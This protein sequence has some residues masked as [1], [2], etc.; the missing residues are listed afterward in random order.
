MFASN[1][2]RSRGWS[3]STLD[4]S[5]GRSAAGWPKALPDAVYQVPLPVRT[6]EERVWL[7]RFGSSLVLVAIGAILKFAVTTSVSAVNLPT[8]GV[9]LMVVGIAGLVISVALASTARR[10][11]VVHHLSQGD[12][13]QSPRREDSRL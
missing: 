6:S 1:A 4:P 2:S 8:V 3:W 10:T 12:Y 13:E 7:M 5:L 11:D 9:V